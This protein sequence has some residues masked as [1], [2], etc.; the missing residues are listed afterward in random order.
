MEIAQGG[1]RL[2]KQGREY[3][4]AIGEWF[5]ELIILIG[6]MYLVYKQLYKQSKAWQIVKIILN[7]IN[8]E[9]WYKQ[10]A[11]SYQ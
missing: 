1:R 3:L 6:C 9:N 10:K 2:T 11:G 5:M 7:Y 8:H 4:E